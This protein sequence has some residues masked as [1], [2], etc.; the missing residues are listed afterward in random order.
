LLEVLHL[1]RTGIA[2]ALSNSFAHELR[3]PLGAIQSYADAAMLYLKRSPP[4]LE[5]IEGILTDIQKEDRRATDIISNLRDLLKKKTEVETDELDLND[6]IMNA[7]GII[8]GEARRNG[9]QLDAYRPNGPLPIRADRIQL[10]QA[11]VNLAVN[12][13]QAMHDCDPGKRALSISTSL[14]TGIPPERLSTIFDAFYTTKGQGTG[15]GLSI[16]STIVQ[17]LGGRI[18][19]ENRPS[20]GALFRFTLPLSKTSPVPGVS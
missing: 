18:W 13:I 20:G 17:T 14:G 1:N 4:N 8:G 7:I 12:G 11:L 10:E 6:V 19:A 16:T 2:G 5:K 3:Q 15:L 9:V